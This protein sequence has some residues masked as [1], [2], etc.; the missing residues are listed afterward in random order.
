MVS[1]IYGGDKVS[2]TT[3]LAEDKITRRVGTKE[4]DKKVLDSV[5]IRGQGFTGTTELLNTPYYVSYL[6]LRDVD[7]TPVGMLFA[8]S[9]QIVVLQTAGNSIQLTFVVAGILWLLAIIPCYLI[10]GYIAKQLK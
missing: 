1:S 6:P 3:L 10:A 4:S 5:L 2:A 9:P 7:Q 8:G